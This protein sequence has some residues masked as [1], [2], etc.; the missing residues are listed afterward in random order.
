M[1]GELPLYREAR[2]VRPAHWSPDGH[3]GLWWD[4]FCDL[5][6]VRF[7]GLVSRPVQKA[8]GG[9][10]EEERPGKLEWMLTLLHRRR[11]DGWVNHKA[12]A[13]ASLRL[14]RDKEL[15]DLHRRLDGLYRALGAE[16][17][18]LVATAPFVTGTG[19]EHPTENGFLFHHTFAVPY[20][21]GSAVKGLVR[22]WAEEAGKCETDLARIFG[23]RKGDLGVGSVVFFDAFPTEPVALTAE[24][25]TPHYQPWYQQG[26]A[27]PP[28]D[29]YDPTPIPFL[30]VAPGARFRFA[31]A[32]RRTGHDGDRE[33]ARQ[34]AE[35]LVQALAELG[36][37]AKTSVGFGRFA[38]DLT[39][40]GDLEAAAAADRA[41]WKGHSHKE[42]LGAPASAQG[43]KKTAAAAAQAL[44]PARTFPIGARVLYAGEEAR[45]VG[46][47]DGKLLLEFE[48]GEREAV[49][50]A[51]VEKL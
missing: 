34:V 19:Y 12:S 48:D 32:P 44:G 37:G 14:G 51:D 39:E 7:D 5:W 24:V 2:E 23:P 50:P 43:A 49:P 30:A 9:K 20:L 36:A 40:A 31:V 41:R 21:S 15:A 28:A 18:E 10:P 35:W 8:G 27:Q 1:A 26:A 47:E 33:D 22:G 29:W 3:P 38:E 46:Y 13:E 25:M 45:V 4:R 17:R 42:P 16:E 6:T 11:P